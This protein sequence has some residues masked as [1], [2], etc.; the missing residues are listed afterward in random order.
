MGGRP[1]GES[2]KAGKERGAQRAGGCRAGLRE[3]G[4]RMQG[5]AG[6]PGPGSVSAGLRCGGLP[7]PACRASRAQGRT[8]S[9]PAS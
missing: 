6:G 7:G 1:A 9:L 8:S 5:A 3:E 2:L 4:G